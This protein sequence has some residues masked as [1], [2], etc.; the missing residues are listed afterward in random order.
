MVLYTQTNKTIF[1]KTDYLTFTAENKDRLKK[2]NATDAIK[3]IQNEHPNLSD[4]I[5]DILG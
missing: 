3:A 2:L 1:P 4:M 5:N